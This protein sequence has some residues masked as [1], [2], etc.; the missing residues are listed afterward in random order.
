MEKP[1]AYEKLSEKARDSLKKTL[2]ALKSEFGNTI[3]II[4]TSDVIAVTVEKGMEH[5]R[6]LNF[7]KIGDKLPV[8]SL[9][10]PIEKVVEASVRYPDEDLETAIQRL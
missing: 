10:Y 4:E 3:E 9:W 8:S 6:T 2:D 5:E 7:T 1:H